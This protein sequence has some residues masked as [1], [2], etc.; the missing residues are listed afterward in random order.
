MKASNLAYSIIIAIASVVILVFGKSILQPLVLAILVWFLLKAVRNFVGKLKIRKK[1]FP[2]W[3]QNIV[4][5]VLIFGVLTL[6]GRMLSN[7]VINL[8]NNLIRCFMSM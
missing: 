8:T 3:L 7:S 6:V 2:S 5:F 1:P 4:A